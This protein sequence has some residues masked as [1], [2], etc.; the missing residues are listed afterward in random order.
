MFCCASL[1]VRPG[2]AEEIYLKT[3]GRG[4]KGKKVQ[5]SNWLC[6]SERGGKEKVNVCTAK[7]ILK[8][9]L[10]SDFAVTAF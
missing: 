6:T 3:Q 8:S 1:K 2:I 5:M 7:G 4:K 10:V 9:S